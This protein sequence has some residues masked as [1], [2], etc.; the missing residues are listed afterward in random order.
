MNIAFCTF[1]TGFRG[2]GIRYLSSYVKSLG[3]SSKMLFLC[4][5]RA[6]FE[7]THAFSQE[8]VNSIANFLL[9]NK[10]ELFGMSVMTGNF[11]EAR[12]LMQKLKKILPNM[13][14]ILGG[15]HPTIC[16]KECLEAGADYV[17]AGDGE[18]PLKKFL[19][20]EPIDR[21]AGFGFIEKD[22]QVH[23]SHASYQEAIALEDLP[24][25]DYEFSD[26]Y[27]LH[28]DFVKS[29]DIE[30]FRKK[31]PWR[32]SYYYLTTS[33]GC[34][35]S[36][37]YCCNV[38]RGALRRNTIKRVFEELRSIRDKLPFI[39]GLNVQDDSFFLGSD[40]WLADFCRQLKKDFGWPFIARIMP[41]FVTDERIEL[42]KKGG[43]E[44]VSIGLQGSDRLNKDLYN[45]QENSQSFLRACRILH[46]YGINFVVDVLLENPYETEVDLKEIAEILNSIPKPFAVLAY[47]L[48]VF[49]GTDLY[50]RAKEDGMQ[51][52]FGANA[53][54]SVFEASCPDTYR[55]PL[56]WRK[57][58]S[59]VISQSPHSVIDSI[60]EQ[61]VM[62]DIG[63]CRIN[64]LYNKIGFR[65]RIAHKLK[66]L[67]PFVFRFALRMYRILFLLN[68]SRKKQHQPG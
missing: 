54:T 15:I 41:K 12:D 16:P 40:A 8:A 58:I 43:L 2:I 53:Y 7:D 56:P 57:L 6:F 20:N 9:S 25:P 45:R 14:Y 47:P 13:K 59:T 32:G 18:I 4:R 34:P 50:E 42:L 1:E 52:K 62:S 66:D 48:T 24:F 61:G 68:K 65:L 36:C 39:C 3:Y 31:T 49:P 30:T 51:S 55:T 11:L 26:T 17:V 38:N 29:L 63:I 64:K 21:I 67:N 10:I 19:N 5:E 27:F 33:R 60:L 28:A 44:H 46:K 37:A 23:M 35:Y 22:G